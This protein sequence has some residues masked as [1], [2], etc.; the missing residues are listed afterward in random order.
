MLVRTPLN[1]QSGNFLLA[2]RVAG[3][4]KAGA[5]VEERDAE[6]MTALMWAARN[7]RRKIFDAVLKRGADPFAEDKNGMTALAHAK[8]HKKKPAIPALE[9][10]MWEHEVTHLATRKPLPAGKKPSFTRYR[11]A[12]DKRGR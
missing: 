5:S 3:L 2:D 9:K 6:G 8:K 4:L 7:Y 12:P 11:G 10:A 1:G